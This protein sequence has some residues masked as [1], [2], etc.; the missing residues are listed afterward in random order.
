MG[1][2]ISPEAKKR[3][4]DLIESGVREGAELLL[5]GRQITD[6][7][8]YEGGN[9]VG[10]TVLSRVTPNMRCYQEEIFGPVLICLEASDCHYI[11]CSMSQTLFKKLTRCYL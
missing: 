9:W 10:P 2:V 5:D 6:P 4:H 3:I 1:P 8:G 11:V 7:N